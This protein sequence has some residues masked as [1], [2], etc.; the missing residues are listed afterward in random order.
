MRKSAWFARVFIL[1]FAIGLFPLAS[2]CEDSEPPLLMEWYAPP[3][4]GKIGIIDGLDLD[5]LEA[6]AES[7]VIQY[8]QPRAEE[9]RWDVVVGMMIHAPAD[10]VWEVATDHPA[11]CGL[12][13]DSFDSCKLVSKEGN[14]TTMDYR[15]HTSVLKFSFD[16]DIIDRIIEDPPYKW[17]IDTVEGSLKGRELDLLL[18][19]RGDDRTMAFL[20][21]YGSMRSINVLVRM[22]LA[23]IP[24]FESPVYASASTY[25]MRSYKNAAE[26]RAGYTPPKTYAPVD[27]SRLEAKTINR[28]CAWYGGLVRET[29][30]GKTINAMAFTSMDAPQKLVWEVMTDFEHYD[31]YF[32]DSKTVVEKRDKHGLVMRQSVKS[33]DVYV[34]SFGFDLHAQYAFEEPERMSWKTIDGLYKDS[35]GEFELVPYDNG[36]KTFVFATTGVYTKRD[37]SLTM[38]IVKSGEFPFESMVNLFFSRDVLTQFKKEVERRRG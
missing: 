27:Y 34:F 31:E 17:H 20:R 1:V 28:L 22:V 18:I 24:D 10:V 11:L 5:T 26:K 2:L 32:P 19:P 29:K 9:G 3:P 6:L 14:V 36:Q 35:M 15:L 8:F 30:D 12:L 37:D 38:K 33:L 25:H 21:Y 13:P 7:G 16:L 23:L 4:G